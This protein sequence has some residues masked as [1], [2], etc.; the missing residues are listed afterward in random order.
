MHLPCNVRAELEFSAPGQR[1]QKGRFSLTI[2][3]NL[4]HS[5]LFHKFSASPEKK[6]QFIEIT[7]GADLCVRPPSDKPVV[8][9]LP[10]QSPYWE[11]QALAW[12]LFEI[13][14][15]ASM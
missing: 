1:C 2:A 14:S 6:E 9:S 4:E 12:H 13:N 15:P 5:D 8:K 3:D 11:R 7:V 10:Q